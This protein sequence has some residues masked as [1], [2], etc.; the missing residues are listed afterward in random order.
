ME[1]MALKTTIPLS[2]RRGLDGWTATALLVSLVAVPLFMCS[3]LGGPIVE[4]IFT[5][6]S[7]A[8]WW[9][10][11]GGILMAVHWIPFLLIWLALRRNGESWESIG[12]D[13]SWFARH[14]LWLGGLLV[15]LVIGAVVAPSVHYDG[16]LPGISQTVFMAGVSTPERLF[17][18]LVAI[19]AG[20]EEVIYR[21]FSFTRLRRIIPNAWII[22]LITLP[23]FVFLHS[24]P[25]SIG[26][27]VAY[28]LAG[29]SFGI[30]F[31]LMKMKRLEI[32]I[33]IHVLIDAG[34][35]IAP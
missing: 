1:S 9:M 20:M 16:K 23:S 12:V 32:L 2:S 11:M 30:P 7:R 17:M 19:T 5:E 28:T 22:L 27:A 3:G 15:L 18:I 4:P 21:G 6:H 34:M 31:I 26:E 13:W 24:V 8:H 10:F 14:R 35:V 25:R 29:L 33:L